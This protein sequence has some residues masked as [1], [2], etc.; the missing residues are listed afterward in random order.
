[1]IHWSHR[2]RP[3]A[4]VV[5]LLAAALVAASLPVQAAEP[6]PTASVPARPSLLAQAQLAAA[7]NLANPSP[8]TRFQAATPQAA[9]P[10]TTDGRDKWSFFKSPVGIAVMATFAVGVG[11]AIYST[12]N[13]RITSPGK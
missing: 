6:P 3:A 5:P 9:A 12:Q 2:W 7:T 11:Y 10:V 13:D 8:A 1:M 4:C